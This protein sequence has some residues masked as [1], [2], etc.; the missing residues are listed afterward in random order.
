MR[1]VAAVAVALSNLHM[2][3]RRERMPDHNLISVKSIWWRRIAR[4]CKAR[5]RS[6]LTSP[7]ERWTEIWPKV[8]PKSN[9]QSRRRRSRRRPARRF[10]KITTRIGIR[11]RSS[12]SWH[13]NPSRSTVHICIWSLSSTQRNFILKRKKIRSP[14]LN[15]GLGSKAQSKRRSS[16]NSRRR[17]APQKPPNQRVCKLLRAIVRPWLRWRVRSCLSSMT[18]KRK[19]VIS[20][21]LKW[22]M[23]TSL[24]HL[25]LRQLTTGLVIRE[26]WNELGSRSQRPWQ[27]PS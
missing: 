26:R 5:T 2:R 11:S 6:H 20:N 23:V 21:C 4:T 27:S 13:A 15:T 12:S 3:R 24:K 16:L 7:K 8:W 14:T 25:L 19:W 17:K 18:P 1:V 10:K 9:S 22:Q